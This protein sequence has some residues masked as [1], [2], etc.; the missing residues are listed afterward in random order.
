[1]VAVVDAPAGEVALINARLVT[2]A[3]QVVHPDLTGPTLTVRPSRA[4]N[5]IGEAQHPITIQIRS[6]V[7]TRT[8]TLC[9]TIIL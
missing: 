5:S 3:R 4:T 9:I 8:E 6:Y 1:M 2:R 7:S